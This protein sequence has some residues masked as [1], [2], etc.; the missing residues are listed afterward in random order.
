VDGTCTEAT[1]GQFEKVDSYYTV[2][3]ATRYAFNEQTE[4]YANVINLTDETD[5]IIARQPYGA[6]GQ[7]PRTALVGISH[8]F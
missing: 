8:S 4:V 5:N 7:A 2:D 1:C 3:L 6:R